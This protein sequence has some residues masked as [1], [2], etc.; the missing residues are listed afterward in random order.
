LDDPL[1]SVEG[2]VCDQRISLDVRQKMVGAHHIMHLAAG[3][4]KPGG[5]AQR[6]VSVCPAAE[7]LLHVAPVTEGLRQVTLG[8][9]GAVTVEHGVHKQ[10]VVG[11]GDA[12]PSG[13]PGSRCLI[14]SHWYLR[15]P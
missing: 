11:G 1:L 5:I 14:R 10:A 12:H 15:K 6:I 3:Q 4:M 13:W 8:D 7:T 2:Y 9:A